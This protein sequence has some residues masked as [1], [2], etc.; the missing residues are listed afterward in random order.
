MSDS[1]LFYQTASRRPRV[2]EA[3]KR[4]M[5]SSAFAYRLHFENDASE[6][7]ATLTA[8]LMPAGLVRI[9]FVSRGH[10]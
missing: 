9:F 8:S 4:Q 7:L 1:R 3:M 6:S 2:L 5:D 10:L